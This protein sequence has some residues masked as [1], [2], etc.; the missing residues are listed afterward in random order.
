MLMTVFDKSFIHGITTEEAAVFDVHFMSNLTPLFFVEVLAD[1]E[2]SG[3]D[4]RSR[5]GLVKDLASKT[6]YMQ[7]YSNVPHAYLAIGD[8]V[9]QLVPMRGVPAVAGGRRVQSAEGLGTVYDTPPELKAAHR[10]QQGQFGEDEYASA[11][12]WREMLQRAPEAI[13]EFLGGSPTRFTFK[14][15]ERAKAFAENVIDGD[16]RRHRTLRSALAVLG[17]PQAMHAVVVGRWKAQGGPK[18]AE[19]APYAR[20]VLLVDL[21]R[22]LA[23]ASGLMDPDKTSNFA[24]V[25]YLYYL[26]FC[27]VFISSD[28]LHRKCV[29]LFLR[30]D[31][32]FVWGHDFRPH[33]KALTEEYLAHPD[34]QEQG[35]FKLSGRRQFPAGSF[36]GDM[37]DRA[38]RKQ[39]KHDGDLAER[40]TPE[41]E[42]ALVEKLKAAAK[43]PPPRA[44]ANLEEEDANTTIERSVP[45]TRGRFP[46]MPKDLKTDSSDADA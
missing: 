10:W 19:F 31:Q 9:G 29:P 11:R 16:G 40:L 6:P 15:L 20:H 39:R 41:A 8:L 44:D 35:L 14:D 26:P 7:S 22:T 43:A 13:A 5:T 24:D 28:K 38:G 3:M 25:A 30:P 4:E 1:L 18:L 37:L 2:K 12:Q 46:M 34:L 33:L 42:R 36:I 17:V 23:M 32:Q 21:F 27:Q 45:R